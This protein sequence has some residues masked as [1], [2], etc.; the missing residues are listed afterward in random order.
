M[1]FGNEGLGPD[2]RYSKLGDKTP[3]KA[4]KAVKRKLGFPRKYQ[5]SEHLLK[6]SESG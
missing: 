2:S 4:L 6:G 5:A 3:L 1:T